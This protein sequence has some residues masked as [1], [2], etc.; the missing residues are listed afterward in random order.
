VVCL[1]VFLVNHLQPFLLKVN[2]EKKMRKMRLIDTPEELAL[3][4]ILF[5]DRLL[6]ITG[7]ECASKECFIHTECCNSAVNGIGKNI[8]H[9]GNARIDLCC[10]D[11]IATLIER[12]TMFPCNNFSCHRKSLMRELRAALCREIDYEHLPS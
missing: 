5:Y 1:F 2:D 10:K 4:R 7:I 6:Y 11:C 3:K 12:F 8:E 9:T